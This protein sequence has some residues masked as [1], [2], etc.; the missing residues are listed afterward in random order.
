MLV[1]A[2]KNSTGVAKGPKIKLGIPFNLK[3]LALCLCTDGAFP[4]YRKTIHE[5]TAY[6]HVT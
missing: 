3:P 4:L 2:H 6:P 1:Y 5:N